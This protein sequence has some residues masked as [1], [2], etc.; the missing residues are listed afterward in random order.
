MTRRGVFCSVLLHRSLLRMLSKF[1]ACMDQY[2]VDHW[3]QLQL[4]MNDEGHDKCSHQYNSPPKQMTSSPGSQVHYIEPRDSPSE[5]LRM[6]T[7]V[8]V[9]LLRAVR[10][11]S[12]S[13][14][15]ARP[16]LNAISTPSLLS[17]APWPRPHGDCGSK[18]EVRPVQEPESTDSNSKIF[19][20][21][22]D[23]PTK[24]S[25]KNRHYTI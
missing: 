3:P 13:Q 8:T 14:P 1:F 25:K 24:E 5:S 23:R 9:R 18:Q 4:A 10:A 16:Y 20:Q 6:M 22:L 7:R 2:P 21:S 11:P 19:V 15:M 17:F 12:R